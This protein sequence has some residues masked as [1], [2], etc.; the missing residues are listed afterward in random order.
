[1]ADKQQTIHGDGTAKTSGNESAEEAIKKIQ[2]AKS[3]G[4]QLSQPGKITFPGDLLDG[5]EAVRFEIFKDYQFDRTENLMEK[6][7]AATIYLP[8]PNVLQPSYSASYQSTEL[9][10]IGRAG[11]SLAGGG[12]ED[13]N[14]VGA[15]ANLAAQN[16]GALATAA[17][18]GIGKLL[19]SVLKKT[20]KIG[21][22]ATATGAAAGAAAGQAVKGA[23][24]GMGVARNPHMAQVFENIQFRSHDFSYKFSPK[25]IQEQNTLSNIIKMFKVAMHPKYLLGDHMFEYPAQFDI[26]I[27]TGETNRHF[28][29]VGISVLTD[30]SVNYLP[31]GPHMH[32]IS[33]ADSIG[34]ESQNIKAPIAVDISMKFTEIKIV[35][36]DE[37]MESNY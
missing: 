22:L 35:T 3:G 11:A 23:Q 27:I 10:V 12:Q 13:T 16:S 2:N 1:M 7:V 31:N 5:H 15:L 25:N 33:G 18:A 24:F 14:S 21:E 19:G 34:F 6:G 9:G 17:G 28:Y 30:M 26:D 8:I 29:N 32:D 20:P 4:F 36:Q 37:I